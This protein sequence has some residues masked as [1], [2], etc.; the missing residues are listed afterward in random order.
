MGVAVVVFLQDNKK[1]GLWVNLDFAG[2]V[3][4]RHDGVSKLFAKPF[5]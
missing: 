1:V 4:Q 2:G 3:P 5:N